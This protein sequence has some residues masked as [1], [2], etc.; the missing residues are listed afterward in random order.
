MTVALDTAHLKTGAPARGERVEK[1]NQLMHIEE[2]LGNTASYAGV[3]AYV[4]PPLS[5][6]S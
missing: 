5:N 2:Q 6:P 1:H 4:R 3:G